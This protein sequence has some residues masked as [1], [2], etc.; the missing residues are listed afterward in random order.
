[1]NEMLFDKGMVLR[2]VLFM[3]LLFACRAESVSAQASEADD[4]FPQTE[5]NDRNLFVATTFGGLLGSGKKG[6]TFDGAFGLNLGITGSAKPSSV[7]RLGA[8]YAPMKNKLGDS[9]TSGHLFTPLFL[10]SLVLF[11]VDGR[12]RSIKGCFFAL[13]GLGWHMLT[14]DDAKSYDHFGSISGGLGYQYRW[15]RMDVALQGKASYIYSA[16]PG[17]DFAYEM[18]LVFSF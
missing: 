5:I 15:Q 9:E 16:T 10:D 13:F 8:G 18:G 4:E 11:G 2:S 3:L 14:L 17:Q 1:M 12:R 6:N 7:G